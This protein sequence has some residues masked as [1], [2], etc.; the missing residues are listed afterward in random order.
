MFAGFRGKRTP[1]KGRG[2]LQNT[3]ITHPATSQQTVKGQSCIVHL[4]ASNLLDVSLF[5]AM[6]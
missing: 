6:T 5:A 1:G 4:P 3:A 2:A